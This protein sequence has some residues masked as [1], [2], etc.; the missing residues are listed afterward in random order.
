[1][2]GITT[3]KVQAI[4]ENTLQT[5]PVITGGTSQS[6][7]VAMLIHISNPLRT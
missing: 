4:L 1:V 3:T 7:T 2:I 6:L 5:K